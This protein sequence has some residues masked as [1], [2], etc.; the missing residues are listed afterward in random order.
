MAE[1]GVIEFFLDL[2]KSEKNDSEVIKIKSG[3]F[4]RGGAKLFLSL[5]S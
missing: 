1:N 4:L 5:H 3:N 2:K